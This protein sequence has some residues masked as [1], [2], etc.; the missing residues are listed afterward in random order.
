MKIDEQ[1]FQFYFLESGICIYSSH[2]HSGLFSRMRAVVEEASFNPVWRFF[3]VRELVGGCVCPLFWKSWEI[4]MW[5]RRIVSLAGTRPKSFHPGGESVPGGCDDLPRDF[6]K[7]FLSNKSRKKKILIIIQL[8]MVNTS[9]YWTHSSI[10][11]PLQDSTNW[12]FWEISSSSTCIKLQ[13]IDQLFFL[14]FW[15]GRKN[16]S[17]G[18]GGGERVLAHLNSLNTPPPPPPTHTHTFRDGCACTILSCISSFNSLSQ[19][20]LHW[21]LI[22]RNPSTEGAF[23]LLT[24][25]FLKSQHFDPTIYTCAKTREVSWN[26]NFASFWLVVRMCDHRLQ[27]MHSCMHRM[28]YAWGP[29]ISINVSKSARS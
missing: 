4:C 15:G 22:K 11:L 16:Y 29:R 8:I 28:Q 10:A 6:L 7:I 1:T 14:F 25:R 26:W 21:W 27:C 2:T 13:N 24:S 17:G 3:Q 23:T 18:G 19:V 12:S 5:S 20:L 9:E